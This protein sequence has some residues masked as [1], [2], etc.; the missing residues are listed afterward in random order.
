MK[1]KSGLCFL[2]FSLLHMQAMA[3]NPYFPVTLSMN[4]RAEVIDAWLEERVETILPEIMRRSGIDMWIIIARE[5]NEDP[6]IKTLL[7]A[8]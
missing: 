3:Q 8:T 7:P 6:V 5:Y 2:L 1:I 4:Q